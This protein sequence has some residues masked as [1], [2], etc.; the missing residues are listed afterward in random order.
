M[1]YTFDGAADYFHT[2]GVDMFG[3]VADSKKITVAAWVKIGTNT[4]AD[5][6]I[7][8]TANAGKGIILLLSATDKFQLLGYNSANTKILDL[9]TP[10]S[11]TGTALWYHIVAS[12]DLATAASSELLINRDS[13][14]TETTATDDTLDFDRSEGYGIGAYNDGTGF[15]DGEIAEVLFYPGSFV[16]VGVVDNARFFASSDGQSEAL[17]NQYRQNVGPDSGTKQVGYGPDASDPTGGLARPHVY[18]HGN[19]TINKGTGKNADFIEKGAPT[20]S[21][22]PFTYRHAARNE[23]KRGAKGERWFDSEQSGFSYPRSKTVIEQREGIPSFGKRIGRDE[24]D[25][26]TRQERPGMSFSQ[27]ILGTPGLEDDSDERR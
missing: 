17:S 21:R 6:I 8:A 14:K 19:F 10:T 18:V 9:V 3:P 27:I 25:D 2:N 26:K 22:G 7:F 24:V 20:S 16:D 23:T 13:D 4:A 12:I 1:A 15:W 11:Y 5:R